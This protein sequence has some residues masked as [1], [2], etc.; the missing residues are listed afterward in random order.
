MKGKIG[1]ALAAGLPVVTTPIGAEGMGLEDG[2]TALIAD[3][4][5]S[6][7]EAVVRLCTDAGLHAHLSAWGQDHVRRHWSRPV[8]ERT[9]L[10]AT[11]ELLKMRPKRIA[12]P[13]RLA[14]YAQ[15]IYRVSGVERNLD[16][17]KWRAI[18]YASRFRGTRRRIC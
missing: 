16:R 10:V 12:L 2:R 15:N 6:F 9:L 13:N 5:A 11:D 3:S 18:S 4:P 14:V 8:V 1:E 17:L 7:A